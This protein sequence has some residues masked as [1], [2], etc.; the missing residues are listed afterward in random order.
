M[1]Y[2]DRKRYLHR[3]LVQPRSMKL[4]SFIR[5]LQ[6]LNYLEEFLPVRRV[7]AWYR[8]Y[9]NCTSICRWNHGDHLPFHANHMEQDDWTRFQLYR[10]CHKKKTDFF[11]TR[12]ENLEPKEDKKKSSA[13]AKKAKIY[14]KKRKKV[15]SDSSI[16]EFSKESTEARRPRKKYCILHGK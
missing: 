9:R 4:R 1:L 8:R 6:E 7:S 3:H 14:T 12:I 5:R 13:A 2:R 16:V 15:D 11:E 10:F